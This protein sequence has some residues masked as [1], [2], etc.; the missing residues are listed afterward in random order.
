MIGM[1]RHVA[2]EFGVDGL[3]AQHYRAE[4][5]VAAVFAEAAKRQ[6]LASRITIDDL[7]TDALNELPY[8]RLFRP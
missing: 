2:V 4:E 1:D 6:G 7:V 3:S 8:Q 5:S